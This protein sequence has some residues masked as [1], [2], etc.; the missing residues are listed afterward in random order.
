MTKK[1]LS[2]I[3]ITDDQIKDMPKKEEKPG[4][5]KSLLGIAKTVAPA[6]A[7]VVAPG[8][9]HLVNGLL[10][11]LNDDEWFS[12]FQGN[13]AAFN[14]LLQCAPNPAAAEFSNVEQFTANAELALIT[15]RINNTEAFVNNFMPSV[16]AYVRDKTKNVLN[17]DPDKYAVTFLNEI[18]LVSLYYSLKK[19]YELALHV[20][21]N[22]PTITST[23]E[24]LKPANLS[25][26]CGIIDSLEGYIRST[27]RLPYALMEYLRWRFGTLFCSSNTGRPGFVAYTP[28]LITYFPEKRD[29]VVEFSVYSSSEA[30]YKMVDFENGWFAEQT[31]ER[32]S[33]YIESLK[34]AIASGGRA[35]A[36]FY[37]AYA[38]HTQRLD[39]EARHF[40]EKEYNLRQ[41][42][43]SALKP[44]GGNSSEIVMDSRLDM[45]AAIQAITIST[46]QSAKYDWAT[47]KYKGKPY[48]LTPFVCEFEE[49]YFTVINSNKFDWGQD[50]PRTFVEST[51]LNVGYMLVQP[52]RDN[53]F[54]LRVYKP[55]GALGSGFQMDLVQLSGFEAG[56]AA[57][58]KVFNTNYLYTLLTNSLE[59][60]VNRSMNAMLNYKGSDNSNKYV[61]F[62]TNPLSY[63]RAV[64]ADSA[65]ESIQRNAILNLVRGDYKNKKPDSVK[66][67]VKEVIDTVTKDSVKVI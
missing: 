33:D 56:T 30:G 20:P 8:S 40:D 43:T 62:A 37:T 21:T 66:E 26:L 36:D 29:D 24:I 46:E 63:D 13:G 47:Q 49:I 61:I 44:R 59:M 28:R 39:V 52:V 55:A 1:D 32:F 54:R 10:S 41:N 12:E 25:G 48:G 18:T 23:L 15:T 31:P 2:Q 5:W 67:E 64:I 14:E 65:L 38:D 27:I 45:N 35:A 11:T 16:L 42:Y 57:A 60:H 22:A 51:S 53:T 4:F 17:D 7:N 19:F 50:G 6:V 34:S 3:T 58:I 9:G